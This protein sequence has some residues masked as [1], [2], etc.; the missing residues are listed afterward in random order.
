M[1]QTSDFL[2]FS[3]HFKNQTID[4]LTRELHPS[5]VE[6]SKTMLRFHQVTN[7]AAIRIRAQKIA[8]ENK[9]DSLFIT[10]RLSL[11][12]FKAFFFDMDSTL[13][14][15]ETLDEMAEICGTGEEC[16]RITA[17]TMNGTIKNY[18]ESLKAR[19]KLLQGH[20]ASAL[21]VVRSH[22]KL[23]PGVRELISALNAHNIPSY[24]LSSGFT[25][26]TSVIAQELGMTGYHSN[27]LGIENGCFTGEVTGPEG[28]AII[29][30]A[31]KFAFVAKTMASLGGTPKEAVCCGDGSNDIC[32]VSAAGL[33]VGFRPKSVLRPHCRLCLDFTGFDSLL[34][35]FTE[36]APQLTPRK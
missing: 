7:D 19:V 27:V 24:V 28:S 3:S 13:V 31:G 4:E 18:A 12:H 14:T 10:P 22:T 30:A 34:G 9:A 8:Y 17:G 1:Q 11:S 29:D 35:L 5:A 25:V 32:M 33:G 16:A 20:D 21:D 36:T 23:N 15:T 26:L 6:V 2:C